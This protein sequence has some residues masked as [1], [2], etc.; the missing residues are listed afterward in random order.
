MVVFLESGC[1][2]ARA[3]LV[4]EE[5]SYRFDELAKID[6]LERAV[7]IGDVCGEDV[8]VGPRTEQALASIERDLCCRFDPMGGRRQSDPK[9]ILAARK[10]TPISRVRR[11]ARMSR[12]MSGSLSR[13]RDRKANLEILWSE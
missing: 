3:R 8:L 6:S 1:T 13:I 9:R 7:I 5:A 2:E 10:D 4:L 11:H 12:A